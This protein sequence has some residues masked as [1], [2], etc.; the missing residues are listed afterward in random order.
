MD[1]V[2][3]DPDIPADC[4]VLSCEVP[5]DATAGLRFHVQLDDRFFEVV[6][7]EGAQPGQTINIVVPRQSQTINAEPNVRPP[8]AGG[9][10]ASG[11]TCTD[12]AA[13]D[14]NEDADAPKE[15]GPLQWFS[16][17]LKEFDTSYKVSETIVQTATPAVDKLRAFEEHYQLSQKVEVGLAKT[18]ETIN[19][20]DEKLQISKQSNSF[21][22]TV[23]AKYNE[24]EEK[25]NFMGRLNNSGNAMFASAREID[26]KYAISVST[27][28]F[29]KKSQDALLGLWQRAFA[30]SETIATQ[31]LDAEEGN[32]SRFTAEEGVPSDEYVSSSVVLQEEQNMGRSAPQQIPSSSSNAYHI[33]THDSDSDSDS[34][35]ITF[36]EA[37]EPAVE[38]PSSDPASATASS[39]LQATQPSSCILALDLSED[40][41]K[42][43]GQQI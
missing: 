21:Y 32:I 37:I 6:T 5:K 13:A 33:Q 41:A 12:S 25:T 20:T 38:P 9:G 7:P 3:L 42:T 40:D 36:N 16:S 18:Q 23:S 14:A 10:A 30:T 34:E 8:S 2:E 1:G 17:K 27:A 31:P 35:V 15:S 29:V 4:M 39:I 28:R 43:T 11:D 26:A 19:W 24:F 22:E